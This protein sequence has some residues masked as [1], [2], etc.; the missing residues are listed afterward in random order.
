MRVAAA[1]VTGVT[2]LACTRGETASSSAQVFLAPAP[3]LGVNGQI[4]ACVRDYTGRPVVGAQAQLSGF[5]DTRVATDA[6]GWFTIGGLSPG[7]WPVSIHAD[8][9]VPVRVR[10][11][12]AG[13]DCVQMRRA[14]RV[15]GTVLD[16][17]GAPA[18]GAEVG[19]TRTDGM[20]VFHA[21]V[22]SDAREIRATLSDGSN[23][24][25]GR[26]PLDVPAGA[27]AKG[28]IVRLESPWRSYVPLRITDAQGR[29]FTDCW[30]HERRGDVVV[31]RCADPPGTRRAWRLTDSPHLRRWPDLS[32]D[33]VTQPSPD[34]APLDVRLPAPREFTLEV[35][36]PD[37]N[38]LPEGTTPYLSLGENAAYMDNVTV[39]RR[40]RAVATWRVFAGRPYVMRAL[41]RGF[42]IL[43][44]RVTD[45]EIADG[46]AIAQLDHG[47]TV[48]GRVVSAE[49]TAVRR[50]QVFLAAAGDVP[51]ATG[52]ESDDRGDDGVFRFEHV[53]EGDW[54]LLVP[55]PRVYVVRRNVSVSADDVDLGDVVVPVPRIVRGVVEQDGS[56]CGGVR[57]QAHWSGGEWNEDESWTRADGSFEVQAPSIAGGVLLVRRRGKGAAIV[58]LDEVDAAASLRV[59]L[60]PLGQVDVRV[61][62]HRDPHET[63]SL[64]VQTPDG[65]AAWDPEVVALDDRPGAESRFRLI[66]LPTTRLAVGLY[67]FNVDREVDV[68]VAGTVDVVLAER[69]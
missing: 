10:L 28:V 35:R 9:Y 24:L 42:A 48:R 41:V 33:V 58:R 2:L 59:Q 43:E 20:G 61:R 8:G 39:L 16:P 32:L 21:N 1:I 25:Q 40:E 63:W 53:G 12:V 66:G 23:R 31:F 7:E 34:A 49:P 11:A 47:V 44:R 46:R 45:A 4:T 54:L 52:Y 68:P 57:V 15:D 17:G 56:P 27:P 38:A 65:A 29:P 5:K 37:G 26:A 13:V 36:G 3:R 14:R 62:M 55:W 18:A 50:A 30:P 51:S 64:R 6:D 22:D 69:P 67:N 19:D 60:A